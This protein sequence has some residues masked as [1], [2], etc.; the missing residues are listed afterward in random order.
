M[1]ISEFSR[2]PDLR[3][4]HRPGDIAAWPM[5][6]GSWQG[7]LIRFLTVCGDLAFRSLDQLRWP[8]LTCSGPGQFESWGSECS[9]VAWHWADSMRPANQWLVISG[10]FFKG[11]AHRHA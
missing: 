6:G 3:F 4:H 10:I 8:L 5:S 2:W 9:C 7:A 1:L 11:G